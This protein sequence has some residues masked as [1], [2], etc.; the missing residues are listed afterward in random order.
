MLPKKSTRKKKKPDA[1]TN[2]GK[3]KVVDPT[4]VED[5]ELTTGEVEAM[6]KKEGRSE[7]L[8]RRSL[9]LEY[10]WDDIAYLAALQCTMEEISG[11]FGRSKGHL[12]RIC[13]D[14]HGKSFDEW[15]AP[16]RE[17]GKASLRR[18]Q[19]I[20][21]QQGNPAMLI[22]LGKNILGQKDKHEI[23]G[24]KENP[25]AVTWVDIAQKFDGD[26]G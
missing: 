3:T 10:D 6:A 12:A 4:V 16:Y 11:F 21:A 2:R 13:K 25:V 5:V 7:V 24:D 19:W 22:W 1:R 20:K 9:V 15:A 26:K 17:R 23:S 18:L 8:M 14:L